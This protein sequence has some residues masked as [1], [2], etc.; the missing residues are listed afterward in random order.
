[1]SII[2]G[3]VGCFKVL[4][5]LKPMGIIRGTVGCQWPML[6]DQELRLGD[7]RTGEQHPIYFG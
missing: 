6:F 5:T 7:L 4:K 2:R 1:M 3:A